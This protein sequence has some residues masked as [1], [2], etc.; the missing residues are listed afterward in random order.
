MQYLC[1]THVIIQI[2]I[3]TWVWQRYYIVKVVYENIAYVCM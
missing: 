3:M 1:H 2:C